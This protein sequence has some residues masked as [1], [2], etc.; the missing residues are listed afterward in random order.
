MNRDNITFT[1]DKGWAVH[2][3]MKVFT[4][5]RI[6]NYNEKIIFSIR[7]LN[8]VISIFLAIVFILIKTLS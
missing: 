3:R 2:P 8:L 7:E 5:A 4:P 6:T 1:C